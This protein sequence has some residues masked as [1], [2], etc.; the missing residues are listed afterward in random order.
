VRWYIGYLLY[1]SG[2]DNIEKPEIFETYMHCSRIAGI[3]KVP[4]HKK[5]ESI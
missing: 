2:P 4:P 1:L 5:L 3:G